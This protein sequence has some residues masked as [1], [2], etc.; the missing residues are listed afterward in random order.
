[1]GA[2]CLPPVLVPRLDL[3]IREL[4]FRRKLHPVL[5]AEVLLS[6][7]AL[8][9][10]LQLVIRERRPRFPLLFTLRGT[11]RIRRALWVVYFAACAEKPIHSIPFSIRNT[12]YYFY[13][14]M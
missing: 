5:D 4:Q 3:R 11:Q 14:F 6:L 1:M 8:F 9:Q 2:L 12:Y 10:G 7:K 13:V